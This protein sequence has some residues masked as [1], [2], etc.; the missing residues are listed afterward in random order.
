[1]DKYI[2][3][4]RALSRHRWQESDQSVNFRRTARAHCYPNI[5]TLWNERLLYCENRI[6]NVWHISLYGH[7]RDEGK[8]D[9]NV[10]ISSSWARRIT[11]AQRRVSFSVFVKGRL[12]FLLMKPSCSRSFRVCDDNGHSSWGAVE[13]TLRPRWKPCQWGN[14]GGRIKQKKTGLPR[15]RGHGDDKQ[16]H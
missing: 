10:F 2:K 13:K 15:L 8:H 5:Q 12:H 4:C 7:K 14:A 9:G 16:K 6:P 11:C 3:H 1:M